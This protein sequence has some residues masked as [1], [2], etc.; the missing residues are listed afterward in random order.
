MSYQ[1]S[2]RTA[3]QFIVEGMGLSFLCEIPSRANV[4]LDKFSRQPDGSVTSADT[5]LPCAL[6]IQPT[7]G[8]MNV[9]PRFET[10]TDSPRC[11]LAF[12]QAMPLDFTGA[13]VERVQ[14]ELQALAAQFIANANASGYFEPIEGSVNYEIGFDRY[15]ANLLVFT[16]Y[17]TLKEAVGQC[18]TAERLNLV[19]PRQ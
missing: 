18:V 5:S 12:L 10:F 8:T 11:A 13:D 2:I 6:F 15:D 1:S 16:I 9:Q 14:I 19:A 7:Q 3:V 17:P 4:V